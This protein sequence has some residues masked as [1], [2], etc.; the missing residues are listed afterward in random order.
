MQSGAISAQQTQL[1]SY[2]SPYYAAPEM[3]KGLEISNKVD[4]FSFG[5]MFVFC[6]F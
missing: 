1:L 2:G 6:R 3:F 5:V 4:V